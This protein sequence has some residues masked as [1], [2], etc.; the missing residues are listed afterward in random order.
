MS[1]L[2]EQETALTCWKPSHAKSPPAITGESWGWRSAFLTMRSH[3]ALVHRFLLSSASTVM[4]KR[5]TDSCVE[6][7][8]TRSRSSAKLH[9][10]RIVFSACGLRGPP[11]PTPAPAKPQKGSRCVPVPFWHMQVKEEYSAQI[12][13]HYRKRAAVTNTLALCIIGR[14]AHGDNA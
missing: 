7:L 14:P 10:R 4:E 5:L 6:M 2:G 1:L 13:V 8:S 3:V 9:A 11:A 12:V